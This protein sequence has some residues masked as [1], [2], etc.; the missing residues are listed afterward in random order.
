MTKHLL[1][2]A[3]AALL[4]MLAWQRFGADRETGELTPATIAELRRQAQE[5][6][7]DT[8]AELIDDF[9]E[10]RLQEI[11]APVP[12]TA[13]PEATPHD[14]AAGEPPAQPPRNRLDPARWFR[15]APLA[16]TIDKIL[17]NELLNPRQTHLDDRSRE[18]LAELASIYQQRIK[19][20]LDAEGLE[21]QRN[22]L[23]LVAANRL[24]T[25]ASLRDR[26]TAE[27]GRLIERDLQRYS[28]SEE[29]KRARRRQLEQDALMKRLRADAVT[30]LADGT[31]YVA[32]SGELTKA[33]APYRDYYTYLVENFFAHTVAFLV[34]SLSLSQ[35]EATALLVAFQR[36]R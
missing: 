11:L 26:L 1:T 17:G 23:E 4:L 5:I 10:Q 18:L 3:L 35:D 15:Y 25:L 2:L 14:A 9:P 13:A 12:A 24:P 34:G 36:I 6:E 28:G 29:G 30:T 32:C 21:R 31:S 33:L 27:D 8:V 7:A 20:A 19:A 16:V 22:M